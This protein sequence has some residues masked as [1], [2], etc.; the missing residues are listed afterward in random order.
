MITSKTY[1]S[2]KKIK[3][4]IEK[5][6]KEDTSRQRPKPVYYKVGEGGWLSVVGGD[7][8]SKENKKTFNDEKILTFK[9]VFPENDSELKTNILFFLNIEVS[10][11]IFW[12]VMF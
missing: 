6:Y 9:G 1:Q 7:L 5:T 12:K 2:T 3:Y 10:A 8:Q 11:R 4:N